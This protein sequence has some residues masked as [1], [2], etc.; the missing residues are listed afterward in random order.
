M[1]NY[2]SLESKGIQLFG[3]AQ[4]AQRWTV[5]RYTNLVHNT[6]AFNN[7]HQRVDGHAPITSSSAAPEFMHAITDMTEVYKG[8]IKKAQRGIAVVDKE[9]VVVRDEIE[10]MDQPTT[11]RW[12]LLTPASVR[13]TGSNSAELTKDGKKLLLQVQSTFPVTMKTWSTDPPNS[14][15]A[16]NPGTAMVGFEVSVPANSRAD[17]HVVLIPSG[18]KVKK[19]VGPLKEWK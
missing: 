3:R 9:Y 15:D 19:K 11:V 18:K 5:F 6:L 10:T 4:N 8:M 7:Q 12:T 17:I 1:Q 14:Y 13:I 16:P 2:E